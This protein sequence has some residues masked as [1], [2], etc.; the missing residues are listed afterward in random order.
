[1]YYI[2]LAAR[3]ETHD[4]SIHASNNNSA[5]WAVVIFCVALG[6]LVALGPSRRTTEIKRSKD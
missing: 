3:P 4:V 5:S 2:L 1:M 6:L